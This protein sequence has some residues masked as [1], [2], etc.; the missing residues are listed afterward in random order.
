MKKPIVKSLT[1]KEAINNILQYLYD[2]DIEHFYT[3]SNYT[4]KIETPSKIYKFNDTNLDPRSFIGFQMIKRDLREYT[5]NEYPNISKFNLQYFESFAEKKIF[6]RK[7]YL[8]DI[9]SAYATILKNDGFICEDTFNYINNLPKS[10]RLSCVGMLASNKNE[11]TFKGKKII[12]IQNIVSAEENY[13]WYCVKRTSEIMLKIAEQTEPIFYWVDGIYFKNKKDLLT[14]IEILKEEKYF[15]SVK[16]IFYF[17]L[18]VKENKNFDLLHDIN[19]YQGGEDSTIEDI[20]KK[21]VEY[22]TFSIPY[23]KRIH[24]ILENY[25]IKKIEKQC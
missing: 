8:L 23:K 12:S 17:N 25:L 5:A 3:F 19:F 11:Y 16:N 15:Y 22:K 20:R 10:A 6:L 2:N 1:E 14:A 24:K 9:K 18:Q 21:E 4:T 7:A 13:F